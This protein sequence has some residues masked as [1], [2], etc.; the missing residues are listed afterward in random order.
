MISYSRF[1]GS[2]SL[3]QSYYD[4]N[5]QRCHNRLLLHP[6]TRSKVVDEIQ[7]A[8]KSF[9]SGS[10]TATSI[11]ATTLA[12]FVDYF[13]LY[14]LQDRRKLTFSTSGGQLVLS[15]D[16]EVY[17]VFLIVGTLE[18][19]QK[20]LIVTVAVVIINLPSPGI[21]LCTFFFDN[22]L[23]SSFDCTFSLY[24]RSVA[25][26]LCSLALESARDSNNESNNIIFK[27]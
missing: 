23:F 22:L 17:D 10:I 14:S 21:F 11:R 15:T 12:R 26:N 27:L 6:I 13:S 3:T 24:F 4:T 18:L 19:V 2:H 16:R 20:S 8:V 9:E 25:R 1:I 7:Q 5:Q